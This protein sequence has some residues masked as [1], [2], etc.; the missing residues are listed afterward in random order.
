MQVD[1]NKNCTYLHTTIDE[2]HYDQDAEGSAPVRKYIETA[3]HTSIG[4]RA[5]SSLEM[6]RKPEMDISIEFCIFKFNRGTH[7]SGQGQD[8]A[9]ADSRSATYSLISL[10]VLL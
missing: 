2:P 1:T 3:R 8:V 5:K 9:A 6:R 7:P 10:I 4:M